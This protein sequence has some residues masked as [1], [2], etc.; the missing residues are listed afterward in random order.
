MDAILTG[1]GNYFSVTGITAEAADLATSP[2]G[3]VVVT[4][5]LGP[6]AFVKIRRLITGSMR[7]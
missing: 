3:L 1:A 6:M 2:L 5:T 7:S 4:F